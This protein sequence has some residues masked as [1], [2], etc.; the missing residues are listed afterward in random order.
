MADNQWVQDPND[1]N[2]MLYTDETGTV[3]VAVKDTGAKVERDASGN[4]TDITFPNAKVPAA[5]AETK[6][7]GWGDRFAD[8]WK[9]AGQQG[10]IGV[11][12]RNGL[13]Y[14]GYGKD[15]VRQMFP[16]L[17]PEEQDNKRWELITAT[18][19]RMR[20]EAAARRK[21]DPTWKPDRSFFEQVVSGDWIP[22]LAGQVFGGF[23]PENA[24][25]P[26]GG[27]ATRIGSQ[28]AIG[29]GANAASQGADIN[30]GVADEFSTTEA[31]MDGLVSMAGQTGIEGFGK[32]ANKLRG[33]DAPEGAVDAPNA[34]DA[35]APQQTVIPPEVRSSIRKM[36][37]SGASVE[38]I[39][40]A[41]PGAMVGNNA[42][43]LQWYVD[44]KGK[45]TDLNWTSK[46]QVPGGSA[47]PKEPLD[48]APEQAVGPSGESARVAPDRQQDFDGKSFREYKAVDENGDVVHAGRIYDDGQVIAERA[49]GTAVNDPATADFVRFRAKT[50]ETLDNLAEGQPVDPTKS[51]GAPAETDPELAAQF[52]AEIPKPTRREQIKAATA[53][54]DTQTGPGLK[55]VRPF[56]E[57]EPDY[58]RFRYVTE[59]GKTVDGTY[60]IEDGHIDNLSIGDTKNPVDLGPKEL[61]KLF[62]NLRNQHPEARK[63]SAYRMTGARAK[64]G[65]GPEFMEVNFKAN[66]AP[67]EDAPEA[68]PEPTAEVAPTPEEAPQMEL[69]GYAP[70]EV[71]DLVTRLTGALKSAGKATKEQQAANAAARKEQAKALARARATS[72]GVS[73]LRA[74]QAAMRQE[75]PKITREPIDVKFS[76]EE[77]DSL[78]DYV[79]NHPALRFFESARAREGLGKLMSGQAIQPSELA[80]LGK[81]FPKDFV[82]ASLKARTNKQK[83]WDIF[84]NVLN[85]PRAIRSSSDLSAPL[86]QGWVFSTRKEFYKALPGMFRQAFSEKYF[87][88][89]MAEIRAR[90]SYDKMEQGGVAFSDLSADLNRREEAF[91][92]NYAEMIPGFGRIVRGSERGY[93]GFLNKV[94][95]DVFDDLLKKAEKLGKDVD[96]PQFLADLGGYVNNATGRG[97]LGSFE[98]SGPILNALLF[99]PRLMS[100]RLAML[101]PVYYMSLDPFVRKQ[102]IR[103]MLGAS[104]LATTVLGLAALNGADV[105]TDPRSSDFAKIRLGDDRHDILG[106]FGQYITFF[107]KLA[108]NKAINSSG[109]MQE[110]GE[111]RFSNTRLDA[112]EKFFRSKASPVAGYTADYLD[113]KNVIG[114]PFEAGKNTMQLF[115][116]MFWADFVEVAQEEGPENLGKLTPSFFGTG[117]SSYNNAPP[118]DR[119]GQ[120]NDKEGGRMPKGFFASDG[121]NKSV[122]DEIA[123]FEK[124]GKKLFSPVNKKDVKDFPMTDEQFYNYQYYAGA[125][126]REDLKALMQ[127]P[128]YKNATDEEKVKLIKKAVKDQKANARDLLFPKQ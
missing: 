121:S 92:S 74:E 76:Q 47:A 50:S 59:D 123:K 10:T 117:Y 36:I 125:Y 9:E 24:I 63:I 85:L 114:E 6:R 25:A 27:A 16:N 38:D 98:A 1:P 66:N 30:A 15:E 13:F 126:I 90:P 71:E 75:F 83:F 62:G 64:E 2:R 61:R 110:M 91:S 23:G 42:A 29:T 18:Q 53:E 118:F 89:A 46:E 14:G 57:D 80:L 102:A 68:A 78:F 77:L 17:S 112:L 87:N 45:W 116:P 20:E 52:D 105:E 72:S 22:D 96:D 34:P 54:L 65:K 94:R 12:S 107:S 35:P 26:G 7:R 101:N 79:K 103:D 88:D 108:T 86:R 28:F 97:S 106:G 95:A 44:N 122:I 69:N 40:K 67:Q 48:L 5:P 8:S 31:L 51:V 11:L 127:E 93:T 55:S 104:S 82:E 115:V 119:L 19:K 37:D 81:V 109:V 70:P 41:Y 111:G 43:S 58:Y 99:S 3:H 84:G 113:N 124:D 4:V 33:G 120:Q 60:T 56:P 32:L 100:A 73:G 39:A 49:D 128:E 21:A